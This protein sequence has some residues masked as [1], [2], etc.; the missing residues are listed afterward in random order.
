VIGGR[1][2][3]ARTV[4]SKVYDGAGQKLRGNNKKLKLEVETKELL[5]LER[6]MRETVHHSTGSSD[7]KVV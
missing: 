4:P 2:H 3:G 1:K 6:I 5:S 7:V